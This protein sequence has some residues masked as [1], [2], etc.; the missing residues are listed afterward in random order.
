MILE[1]DKKSKNIVSDPKMVGTGTQ[2]TLATLGTG[3]LAANVAEACS[4]TRERVVKSQ[5][6]IELR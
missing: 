6:A 3:I 5:R 1:K 2:G 4:H